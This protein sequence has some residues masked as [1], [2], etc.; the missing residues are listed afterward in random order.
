MSQEQVPE[1]SLIVPAYNEAENLLI[2]LPRLQQQLRG[3][4]YE[5]IVVNNA[6]V[7][8]SAKVLNNFSPT[9]PKLIAVN[10]PLLGYGRAV[11]TGLAAAR[12]KNLAV[13]R[14]DN[15][16]KPEDLAMMYSYFKE[17][18]LDFC[19]AVRRSRRGE[20][21]RRLPISY[22]YNFLFRRLFELKITDIN[23]VPKIFS[24]VFY[25]Q[26]KLESTDWFIDAEMV[27]KASQMNFKIGEVW[28]DYLPRLKGRSSVRLAHIYQFLKNMFIWHQRMRD[29]NLISKNE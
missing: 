10:E 13:I 21:L 23:A 4:D 9:M 27:I 2:L 12:G 1:L 19:K 7:D 8:H 11:L 28:I 17:H 22:I 25:E 16:E 5:L 29:D 24:R 20:Q 6:S 18:G 26:A 15:Q 14:S 3:I